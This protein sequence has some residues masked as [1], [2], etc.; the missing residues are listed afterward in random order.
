MTLFRFVCSFRF[1][2]VK[3]TTALVFGSFFCTVS[4]NVHDARNDVLPCW[5]SPTNCQLKSLRTRSAETR[6]EEKYVDCWSYH[7]ARLIVNETTWKTV[8]NCR[9]RFFSKNEPWKPSFR[10][11]NLEVGSVFRKSISEIFT[12][13]RIPLQ[14]TSRKKL[15]VLCRRQVVSTVHVSQTHVKTDNMS[16]GNWRQ[17]VTYLQYGTLLYTQADMKKT[18]KICW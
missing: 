12:G 11:L 10:F 14:Y 15:H 2:F 17:Y 1:G 7:A 6:H 18:T 13:F 3:L 9:S 5:I 16:V 8:P 4:F